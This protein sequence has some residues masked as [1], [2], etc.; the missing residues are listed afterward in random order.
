M[1]HES[2]PVVGLP[3]I[4]TDGQVRF[5]VEARVIGFHL[6]QPTRCRRLWAAVAWALQPVICLTRPTPMGVTVQCK[7]FRDGT[8]VLSPEAARLQAGQV[9]GL[10]L[11]LENPAHAEQAHAEQISHAYRLGRRRIIQSLLTLHTG[12]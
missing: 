5:N 9:L 2:I 4:Q 6:C 7:V 8:E 12:N 1:S 3:K 11:V 10:Q